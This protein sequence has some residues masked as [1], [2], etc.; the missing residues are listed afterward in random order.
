MEEGQ[1]IS[2]YIEHEVSGVD[3][4]FHVFSHCVEISTE[5][6]GECCRHLGV[7][8]VFKSFF[9]GIGLGAVLGGKSWD[10]QEP[11]LPDIL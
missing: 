10:I 6:A 8:A 11:F 7:I 1:N 4:T 9:G 5:G 3:I 2:F